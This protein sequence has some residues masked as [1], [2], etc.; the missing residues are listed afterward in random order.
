MR[1]VRDYATTLARPYPVRPCRRAAMTP[2]PSLDLFLSHADTNAPVLGGG[3]PRAG[4][5]ETPRPAA[6]DPTHLADRGGLPDALP[7]QRWGLVV[8]RGD[9]G[10]RL[11]DLVAPLKQKRA[12]D[13]GAEVVVYEVD[14]DMGP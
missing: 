10:K 5:H 4:A 3:L 9:A 2:P 13:Q 14:P 11:L 12:E 6:H 7:D 8:P 1:R